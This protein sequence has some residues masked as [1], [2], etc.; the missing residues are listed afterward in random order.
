MTKYLFDTN[1]VSYFISD[2]YPDL[3]HKILEIKPENRFINWVIQ[4]ELLYGVYRKQRLDLEIKY[5]NFFE[6]CNIIGSDK[7]IVDICA[8]LESLLESKGIIIGLEDIWIASTC[9]VKD[10]VL[11]T[12]NAKHFNHIS[13]L[14]IEHW[15]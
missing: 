6:V 13:E 1:I 8:K 14:K 9:L 3:N 2:K 7:E 12:N 4:Q 10:L 11:V 5:K 15:I